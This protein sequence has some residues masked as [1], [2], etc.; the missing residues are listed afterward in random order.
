MQSVSF[1]IIGL[2]GYSYLVSRCLVR[3]FP[4]LL[5]KIKFK[6]PL[7][8]F[9]IL[10]LLQLVSF[11][12]QYM[13]APMS[14]VIHVYHFI[15][16][17]LT[18]LI[19]IE[20]CLMIRD[21]RK[22]IRRR[23]CARAQLTDYV[24]LISFIVFNFLI[25][26]TTNSLNNT[27]A[28]QSFYITL[29]ENNINA[30][31][32]NMI[33]PLS[34]IIS[35]LGSLYNFQGFYLFLSYLASVFQV[36]S[37][38]IMGWLVP[39]VLWLTV[40]MTFLNVIY[41]F[42]LSSKWY[43][44]VGA[45][46]ILWTFTDMFD[47]FVRYNCYGNNM[48]TFVFVYLMIF[49][50]EY[51][52]SSKVKTLILCA[53]LWLSAISLQSTSLFLGIFLMA[54]YGLYDLFVVKKR[55]L[56]LLIFSAI[57]LMVYASFFLGERG[58][59][60]PAY[61]FLAGVGVLIGC[62]LFKRTRELLNQVLYSRVMQVLIIIAIG[63]MVLLSLWMTPN[64]N[65]NL[66]VSPTQMLQLLIEK[67]EFREDYLYPYKNWPAI[68]LISFRRIILFISA[69]FILHFKDLNSK[70]KLVVGIQ[71][72]MMVVFFNPLVS[73]F[74]STAFTGIVYMRIEDVVLSIFTIG[75][76][77]RYTLTSK[78][79]KYF[80]LGLSVISGLYLVVK[81]DNYLK[82]EFNQITSK[83][84]FNH[85][86]RMDQSLVDVAE[87]LDKEASQIKDKRPKVLTTLHHVNYFSSSYE[88]I[89]IVEHNRRRGDE[90]YYKKYVDIYDLK[91]AI[92]E[93]YQVNEE[94]RAQFIPLVDDY[95][96]DFIVTSVEIAPWLK[97]TLE[98]N[99]NCVFENEDYYIYQM[100]NSNVSE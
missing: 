82:N 45:F 98:E 17:I 42:K 47:Y 40:A 6:W 64:L 100:I 1:L 48:R 3:F 75:G 61:L 35:P 95:Q 97:E 18:G 4:Q 87:T 24:L 89:Y 77:L 14:L 30:A 66:S 91:D 57:P 2:I 5:S 65:E 55:I 31:Q 19:V 23:R 10:G 93:S 81:T 13:H 46:L 21:K 70:L 52:K 96:I 43:L 88:M 62:S 9:V 84:T 29:V 85:L 78:H 63:G 69:Y 60:T 86:Y 8:F 32:I 11:P 56:V 25:C 53:I 92:S 37:L 41:Y 58:S 12:I 38:L 59:W 90:S 49:Y 28:D 94:V 39:I 76:L 44:T 68:L 34:G 36:D 26:Y 20:L 67:Y 27:D 54:A 33:S 74:I 80:I 51:L 73:G 22:M 15:F 83:E 50:C 7:G 16:L 79:L 71:V 99:G 72:I